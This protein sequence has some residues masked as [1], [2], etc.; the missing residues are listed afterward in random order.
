MI[1]LFLIGFISL[2]L[3]R[4]NFGQAKMNHLTLFFNPLGV[5]MVAKNG[6]TRYL[7]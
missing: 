7:E 2:V 6:L 1:K 4:T 5:G 3:V